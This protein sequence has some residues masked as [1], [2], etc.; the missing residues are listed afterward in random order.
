[1]GLG[2]AADG[3][4]ADIVQF[5]LGQFPCAEILLGA[6]AMDSV[7]FFLAADG[8]AA[9]IVQF[10]LGQFPCAEILLG[11]IAVDCV[12]LF[13]TADGTAADIGQFVLGQFPFA[14]AI[15]A[16]GIH[17]V[18]LFL[19]ADGTM[20]N[21]VYLILTQFPLAKVFLG[22]VGIDDMGMDRV[23]D[24]TVADITGF[25]LGHSP[26]IAGI[27]GAILPYHMLP[28]MAAQ[29]A[30][31]GIL[32]HILGED[33]G[34]QRICIAI[35]A[36]HMDLLIEAEGATMHQIAVFAGQIPLAIL[37]LAN[38]GIFLHNASQEQP[39]GIQN[40]QILLCE[41]IVLGS[42]IPPTHQVT[43]TIQHF[44]QIRGQGVHTVD[45]VYH[46]EV[47]VHTS[48]EILLVDGITILIIGVI[49]HFTRQQQL[50]DG[51]A[52]VHTTQINED[53]GAINGIQVIETILTQHKLIDARQIQPN[54]LA[55]DHFRSGIGQ[56]GYGGTN[57]FIHHAIRHTEN[58][59]NGVGHIVSGINADHIGL[60]QF[61]N[62][63][64]VNIVFHTG[65]VFHRLGHGLPVLHLGADL[66]GIDFIGTG[67]G[68]LKYKIL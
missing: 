8:T 42:G 34:I 12:D 17:I 45:R 60:T 3:T 66:V 57:E 18:D 59:D 39:A 7:N 51:N 44:I 55:V 16:V 21:E 28:H 64:G 37:V 67:L 62:L 48:G 10:V 26:G 40:Q 4:D 54:I 15:L 50:L 27:L 29:G 5:V 19:A 36:D 25:I 1:M 2:L 56:L 13:L 63:K 53:H 14:E 65:G 43:I 47:C 24:Q 20:T 23:A 33:P 30:I 38:F 49:C 9:D 61:G 52:I 46:T 6:I 35:A 41:Q 31:S 11:A 58:S 68:G 32:G 22:A